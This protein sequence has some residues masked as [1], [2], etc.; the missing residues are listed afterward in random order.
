MRGTLLWW[1]E[2]LADWL[3]GG[4]SRHADLNLFKW[5]LF[6]ISTNGKGQFLPLQH[7]YYLILFLRHILL[8]VYLLAFISLSAFAFELASSAILNIFFSVRWKL[9]VIV[10]ISVFCFLCIFCSFEFFDENFHCKI[11]CRATTEHKMVYIPFSCFF[12]ILLMT[13]TRECMTFGADRDAR[14]WILELKLS[15]GRK[16]SLNYFDAGTIHFF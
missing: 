3:A 6:V 15:R 12:F 1:S 16:V 2:T 9:F 14:F 4:W 7:S 5:L 13:Y 11:E 10:I 8:Y